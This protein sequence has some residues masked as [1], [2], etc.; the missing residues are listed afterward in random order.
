MF[1]KI[2]QFIFGNM[3]IKVMAVALA[4]AVW[5]YVY[6]ESTQ[7]SPQPITVP[8]VVN[9]PSDV[10][11]MHC[12]DASGREVDHVE[13]ILQGPASVLTELKTSDIVCKVS[14]PPLSPGSV[15]ME[16][17]QRMIEQANFGLPPAVKVKS[18]T[19]DVLTMRFDRLV[20]KLVRVNS[21]NCITDQPRSGR[22]ISS[23]ITRP[24]EVRLK[25]PQT[26]LKDIEEI[27]LVK[28]SV[29]NRSSGFSQIAQIQKKEGMENVTCEDTIFV[30]VAMA[31]ESVQ[32]TLHGINV[33][34][35]APPG[36]T[37]SIVPKPTQVDVMV[38]GPPASMAA[39]KESHVQ[40]FID[41]S[42]RSDVT[43]LQ[44][45]FRIHEIPSVELE[46]RLRRNAPKGAELA[47]PLPEVTLSITEKQ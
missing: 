46:F 6:R 18:C 30:E 42:D 28:M 16:T 31:E 40:I 26:V 4:L 34:I 17:V 35:A 10:V 21:D 37:H 8:V 36:F 3:R 45:G 24:T 19:P 44:P 13:I 29:A 38:K 25:G 7:E 47:E 15:N 33:D 12:E 1:R 5:F 27:S 11:L 22:R 20:E 2:F 23:V 32:K 14:V 43:G 41:L 39:L 9:T